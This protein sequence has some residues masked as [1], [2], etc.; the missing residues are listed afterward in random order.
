MKHYNPLHLLRN[1]SKSQIL[2]NH[3]FKYFIKFFKN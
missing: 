3:V 1:F 2:D